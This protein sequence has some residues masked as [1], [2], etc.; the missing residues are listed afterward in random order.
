MYVVQTVLHSLTAALLIERAL[1]IWDVRNPRFKF[2]YRIMTLILPVVMFPVYSAINIERSGVFFREEDALFNM[3]RWLALEIW[4]TVSVGTLFLVLLGFT[5]VVF[6]FQ[7]MV[8]IIRDA[9]KHNESGITRYPANPDLDMVVTELSEAAGIEKPPV[10]IIKDRNPVILTAGSR[11]HSIVISSGLVEMLDKEQ[12]HSAIAHEFAH[13]M[14]RSNAT[15]WA[16]FLL[17][18]LMFFNPIALIIFRRI[19]Q[20]DEHICDDITVSLTERPDV[21]ASAL[22]VFYSSHREMKA[23]LYGKLSSM[24][25]EIESHSH[26]IMLKERI[27]RLESGR[28]DEGRTFEKGKFLIT[29]GVIIV[30]NYFVL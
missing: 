27:T 25:D 15:T 19:V 6:F 28:L 26:N 8:P 24:K 22:K 29:I 2:R 20:D 16:V 7:E 18:M 14:R 17:R 12:Q 3:N 5:S 9:L 4:N 10:S 21:L 13:I 11:S 23:S 30:I 1:E